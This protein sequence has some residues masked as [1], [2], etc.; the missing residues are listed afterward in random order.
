MCV[1]HQCHPFKSER[2]LFCFLWQSRDGKSPLHMTAVHGR[3]TRSQTL[4]QNGDLSSFNKI[5]KLLKIQFRLYIKYNTNLIMTKKNNIYR[6]I[7]RYFLEA[8]LVA[9]FLIVV[10]LSGP[11]TSLGFLPLQ[12]GKST[13]WTRTATPLC[14]SPPA[15]VMSCSSTRWSPAE[16]TARGGRWVSLLQTRILKSCPSNAL[17][18]MSFPLRP[19]C[20]QAGGPWNVPPPH[21]GPERPLGLL[22]EAAVLRYQRNY[23]THGPLL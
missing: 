15:T 12:A 19:I 23:I 4:I 5:K 17:S 22:S 11:L 7:Y 8:V 1:T 10:S 2:S 16:P 21:G 6:Y 13:A 18:L 14:T 3:F 20:V 9:M